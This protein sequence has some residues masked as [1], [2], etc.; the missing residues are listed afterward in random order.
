MFLYN[1]VE[2]ARFKR[3][4]LLLMDK[5]AIRHYVVCALSPNADTGNFDC[6]ITTVCTPDDSTAGDAN[7]VIDRLS[8]AANLILES[9]SGSGPDRVV[10]GYVN[11]ENFDNE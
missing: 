1:D 7:Q 5:Y 8:H 2:R 10:S 9:E 6:S 4:L 3:D 11:P